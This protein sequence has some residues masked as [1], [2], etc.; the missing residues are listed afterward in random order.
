MFYIGLLVSVLV[1]IGYSIIGL[2]S[3][4]R[5]DISTYNNFF[6]SK[7]ALS[8]KEVIGTLASTNTALALIVFWFSY[9][10]WS[11]GIGAAFWLSICWIAG[12]ELFAIFQKKWSEYPTVNQDGTLKYQTLHEFIAPSSGNWARRLLAIVSIGAFILMVTVELTRGMKIVELLPDGAI[13]DFNRDTFAFILILAA[14]L[15]AAF[16]G[17]KAVVKTDFLQW[18][19]CVIAILIALIISASEIIKYGNLFGSVYSPSSFKLKEFLLIPAQPYFIIGSLFSWGFWF[20]VTMD[21]WQRSAAARSIRIVTKRTRLI[22]YPWFVVLT[23]ASV[24]IGLYVRITDPGNYNVLFPAVDFLKI[25]FQKVWSS[26]LLKWVAF[27]LIFNGFFSAMISTIDTYLL[28]ISHS[29]YRDMSDREILIT[30]GQRRFSRFFSSIMIVGVSLIVLPLFLIISHT[31]HT[32]NSLLYM[33]TSLQFILLPAILLRKR[34]D[35]ATFN[36]ILS[37]IIGLIVTI[38]MIY[39]NL[40]NISVA[41]NNGNI[42]LVMKLYN[43]MYLIPIVASLSAFIGYLFG[44]V[45]KSKEI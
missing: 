19:L 44:Y 10:G 17:M 5:E 24:F 25:A 26:N 9:L 29:V 45:F 12:L 15:Y 21:M 8:V 16:G 32:I 41:Q 13:T 14:A 38:S 3:V 31:N 28:V 11:Y 42:E 7:A 27:I 6:L 4:K 2:K 20:F 43:Y 34:K 18:I 23:C 30:E 39:W 22:L 1:I 37:V 35:K 36:L 40:H 33:A